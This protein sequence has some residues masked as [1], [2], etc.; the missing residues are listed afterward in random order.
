MTV[1]GTPQ[2][3]AAVSQVRELVEFAR[4]QRFRRDEVIQMIESLP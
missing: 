2:Q 1:A 4:L 3:S